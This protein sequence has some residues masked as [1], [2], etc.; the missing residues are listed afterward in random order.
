[1]ARPPTYESP[2]KLTLYVESSMRDRAQ[3]LAKTASLSTSALFSKLVSEY[4]AAQRTLKSH[5]SPIKG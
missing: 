5:V 1:M 2:V 3:A 4:D